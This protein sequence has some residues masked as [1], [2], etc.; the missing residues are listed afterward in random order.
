MNEAGSFFP[1]ID[2]EQFTTV[3]DCTDNT[4][5]TPT[6]TCLPSDSES[7]KKS[8]SLRT[9]DRPH[10]A[11]RS[12]VSLVES[13]LGHGRKSGMAAR[14]NGPDGEII[15]VLAEGTAEFGVVRGL[16]FV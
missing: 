8:L 10:P 16:D 12:S 9:S 2:G 1:G 11:T 6:F 5:A 7:P 4:V 15:V 3:L 13:S 14:R